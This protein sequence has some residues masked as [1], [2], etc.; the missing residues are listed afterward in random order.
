MQ[1]TDRSDPSENGECLGDGLRMVVY[2]AQEYI[3]R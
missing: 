2:T 3:D 1:L